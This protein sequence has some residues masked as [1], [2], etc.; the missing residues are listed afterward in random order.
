MFLWM[1]EELAFILCH[2]H[3]NDR[4]GALVLGHE[5]LLLACSQ[6]CQKRGSR[7][8]GPSPLDR[9]PA[10]IFETLEHAVQVTDTIQLEHLAWAVYDNIIGLGET[11]PLSGLE[12]YNQIIRCLSGKAY[13]GLHMCCPAHTSA[14]FGV[15]V[16]KS[17]LEGP[18]S[19]KRT[20]SRS[21]TMTRD[22][23]EEFSGSYSALRG[24]Q[25]MTGRDQTSGPTCPV[26][27][28]IQGMKWMKE[29]QRSYCDTQLGFW[30][31]LRPLTDGG[32][33]LPINW[34]ADCCLCG[35]G[36]QLSTLP[37]ILPHLHR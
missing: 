25:S 26:N 33:S 17:E 9:L 10:C 36:L 16:A 24:K 23:R 11:P 37:H 8:A 6:C 19:R 35:I 14:S 12:T 20:K 13:K 1:I 7:C 3:K 21:Y 2:L 34:P 31:L 27:P 29:H 32:K 22:V 28:N 4:D 18:D 15:E 30:L 5:L